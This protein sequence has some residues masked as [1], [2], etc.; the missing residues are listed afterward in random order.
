MADRR[1]SASF[2]SCTPGVT[3][4]HRVGALQ[5]IS[6]SAQA[7]KMSELLSFGKGRRH[8]P[9]SR[10]S[11]VV[12]GLGLLCA[13]LAQQSYAQAMPT[14]F[15]VGYQ[16]AGL[17]GAAKKDAVFER[18]LKPLGIETV[19]WSE[20][21]LGPA[22]MDAIGAGAIDF[23]WAGDVPAIDAQ[24]AGAKFVYVACMPASA[25]GMLVQE[26]S[27]I[28]TLADIRG[29]KVAFARATS[30]QSVLLK[31]LAKAG[32]TYGDIVP[33]FMSP[34]AASAALSRGDIDVWVVHDPFF[35]LAER[36]QRAHAIASTKDIVNGNSVYVATP[37][38]ARKYPKTLAAVLDEVT[39]VTTWAAQNRDKF[40]EATSAAIG[41]DVDAVRV[42]IDRSDLTVGPVTREIVAQLQETADVF[43]KLGFIPKPIVVRDAVW[44]I[45]S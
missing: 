28:R 42:A 14:E 18:R 2:S 19:K 9:I 10:R 38:F 3:W 37:E 32:L 8:M 25:H 1:G 4:L 7:R 40:A 6:R 16:K 20:F 26:G 31:L 43:L 13:G 44:P 45:A 12:G 34:K 35:A 15:R 41:M 36:V 11:V 24:S 22:I 17:L 21:E 33:V 29:K 23:G 39:N 27:A 5:R 30:G